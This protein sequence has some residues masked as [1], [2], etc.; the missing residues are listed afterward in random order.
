MTLRSIVLTMA[1]AAI[2][3]LS[4]PGLAQNQSPAAPQA[5]FA[6]PAPLNIAI[7][8]PFAALF[9]DRESDRVVAGVLIDDVGNRLPIRVNLRGIT[10]RTANI[11]DFP[12]LAI[13]FDSPPPANSAFAGQRKLKLVTHCRSSGSSDRLV[14]LE[15]AAYRLYNVLTPKSF[16]ARLATIAYR[17]PD[18]RAVAARPGFFIEDIKEVA[19]RNGLQEAHG[20]TRVP[21]ATLSPFDSALYGLFQHMIANHDWSMRAGPAGEDCCHNAKLIGGLGP[22]QAVPVPYDFD[23][24]G[25]VDASYAFPPE[26]LNLTSVKQRKYRGYCA[27]NQAVLSAAK[28][29]REKQGAMMAE[30]AAI[31]GLDRNS[32]AKAAAFLQPFFNE[33]ASDAAIQSAILSRCSR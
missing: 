20:G 15:Y 28:L 10:R 24:S 13:R 22:G 19:R 23:F 17:E 6:S 5:L 4:T 21:L 11:C 1:A 7:D 12:P 29:M 18:G 30:L 33:I 9:S 16:D 25:F 26:Q 14:L 31:P 2:A 3:L 32:A 27:H 8:A